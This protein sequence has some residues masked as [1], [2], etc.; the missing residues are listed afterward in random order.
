MD[1]ITIA[2]FCATWASIATVYYKLGRIEQKLCD[3]AKL[4]N[5]LNSDKDR[6]KNA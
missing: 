4:I 2:G 5:N 3:L 1:G 6:D